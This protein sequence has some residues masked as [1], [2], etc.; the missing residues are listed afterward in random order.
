MGFQPQFTCTRGF[1]WEYEGANN[2]LAM[3][4]IIEF[5][6]DAK[7]CLSIHVFH[8]EQSD[9]HYQYCESRNHDVKN[10]NISA[11]GQFAPGASTELLALEHV[12]KPKAAS[13]ITDLCELNLHFYHL[14]NLSKT[15][16]STFQR[17]FIP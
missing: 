3:K 12:T 6:S 2:Q 1:S 14:C 15:I 16:F 11:L 8:N 4:Y 9:E 5:G 7:L 10:N 13:S 17:F